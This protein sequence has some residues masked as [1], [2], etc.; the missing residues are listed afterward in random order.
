MATSVKK[1][2]FND[3]MDRLLWIKK[4]LNCNPEKYSHIEFFGENNTLTGC[5]RQLPLNSYLKQTKNMI[6]TDIRLLK[7]RIKLAK[8]CGISLDDCGC[9][10]LPVLVILEDEKN[11]YPIF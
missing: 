5:C 3:L 10:T 11:N 4:E 7:K 6:N 1:I 2:S 8:E 9:R